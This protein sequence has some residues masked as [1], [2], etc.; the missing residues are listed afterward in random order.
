MA[1]FTPG[2]MAGV[3]SGRVGSVVFS[4]NKGG[5]YVRNGTIPTKLSHERAVAVRTRLTQ[6]SQQ[7]Q[8]L[9]D[10]QRA[11]WKSWCQ[12]NTVTNRLGHQV[13][14]PA[15]AAFVMLNTRLVQ[16]GDSPI[17]EPPVTVSPEGLTSL[18]GSWDIGAGDFAITFAPTP[19]GATER[20]WCRAWVTDS[21]AIT[22]LRNRLVVVKITDVEEATGTDLQASIE[23]IFG[24]LGVDETVHVEASIFDTL[25]GQVSAPLRVHGLVEES[26]V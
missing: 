2:P 26:E 22:Y 10:A 12:V 7:W 11:S 20:L 9:T 21:A 3:I 4:H 13:T 19:L 24:T 23:A 14:M 18:S 1:I 6:A 25:S 17:D 5:P 8:A 15:N 16:A